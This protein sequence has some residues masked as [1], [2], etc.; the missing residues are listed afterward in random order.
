MDDYKALISSSPLVMIEF[1]A[2]WCGHC[3]RMM[4]VVA[5]IRELLG[6]SVAIYQLD[7]DKSADLPEEL[8]V[9]GTPTFIIYRDGEQV[10]QF[11]GEIDGNV[12]LQK[13]QSFM[14]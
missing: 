12:L 10:W 5:Q 9:T 11:S 8:G 14:N 3:S 6:D 13:I 7:I 1:Y 4:P 2:T